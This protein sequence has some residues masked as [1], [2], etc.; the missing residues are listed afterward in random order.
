GSG[1][2]EK[3]VAAFRS[4]SKPHSISMVGASIAAADQK[5][6]TNR[7]AFSAVATCAK[8]L[9]G[10]RILPIGLSAMR[11]RN[12]ARSVGMSR[13]CPL[14]TTAEAGT[15]QSLAGHMQ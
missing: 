7:H 3:R 4:L 1:S 14:T 9:D 10:T 6:T 11:A 8:I 12:A 13:R 5:A 2:P 15:G